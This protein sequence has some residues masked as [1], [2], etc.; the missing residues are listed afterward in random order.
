MYV[1]IDEVA[2]NYSTQQPI[3]SQILLGA[4]NLIWC[5]IRGLE[6]EF[7]RASLN[8]LIAA[9]TNIYVCGRSESE[10]ERVLEYK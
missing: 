8:T 6:F 10:R 2:Q 3:R 9:Y 7:W 4:C 1:Y 5:Q